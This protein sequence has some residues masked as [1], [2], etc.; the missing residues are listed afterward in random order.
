LGSGNPVH[1]P[2]QHHLRPVARC[3][4]RLNS[5]FLPGRLAPFEG[6]G[7]RHQARR[8]AKAGLAAEGSI[9]AHV[10]SDGR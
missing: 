5:P 3:I 1:P 7:A 10:T 4:S 9:A 8:D 6:S 2:T